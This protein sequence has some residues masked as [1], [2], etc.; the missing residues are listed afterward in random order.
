MVK[1]FCGIFV[2]LSGCMNKEKCVAG[3]DSDSDGLEDCTEIDIGTDINLADSDGDGISDAEEVDCISDPLNIDET[4]YA[5]GWE[6]RAPD[7]LVSTGAEEGDVIS[8]I[9]LSDQCGE[10]VSLW[11]FYGDY[12]IVYL[13]VGWCNGCRNASKNLQAIQEEFITE[14]GLDFQFSLVL[15]ENASG[16]PASPEDGVAY[17][18]AINSPTFPVFADGNDLV[19]NATPLTNNARPEMCALSPELEIIGCFTGYDGHENALNA[20]KTHAGQ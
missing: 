19:V 20:I 2:L 15:Y 8:N 16:Y 18:E 4:C 3:Q 12:Q 6:H 9:R 11:D 1:Y 7:S 10:E 17:A 13:T 14:T 5:C